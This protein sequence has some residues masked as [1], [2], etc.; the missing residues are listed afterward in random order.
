[1]ALDATPHLSEIDSDHL[2]DQIDELSRQTS[3]MA[4]DAMLATM[5]N[6][7]IPSAE[8]AHSTRAL[9]NRLAASTRKAE[10]HSRAG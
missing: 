6:D 1:M 9:A 2:V 8:A 5:S 7:A 4:L 10:A 3:L